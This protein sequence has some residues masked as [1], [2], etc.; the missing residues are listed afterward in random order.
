MNGLPS[1]AVMYKAL[2]NRDESFEGIFF[3]GVKSTGIFC[4]P[5]CSARKPKQINVEFYSSTGAA[6][7]AGYRPCKLCKPLGFKGEFPE[8]LK[9]LMEKVNNSPDLSFKD[10]DLRL[11]GT[12]PN[13]VRRWF[14]KNHGM[15]FQAYLRILRMGRAFGR[16]KF[17]E[18]VTSTAFSSGYGSLSG[19]TDSFKRIIGQS[20]IK[21]TGKELIHITRILTPLGP[22]LA[23]A[24]SAGVCLLEFIDRRMLET[25]IQ[26]LKNRLNGEFFPG[27]CIHFEKLDKEIGQYFAGKRKSFSVPLKLVG[28]QFQRKVWSELV[29]IPYGTTRAYNEIANLI[30]A[31][32]SVRAVANANGS[33]RIA[34]IIPCHRVIGSDGNL[35]GYGGGL[36]RKRYLLDMERVN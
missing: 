15:T 17:G 5:T 29:K 33:N 8:W 18:D 10:R 30:G 7:Q 16:I 3:V 12:D 34:I 6:L 11:F 19:F 32:R 13:R 14:K 22:M 4:R 27:K 31:E 23:G 21:S 1:N 36:W 26:I 25:Q 2:L 28:T 35:T 20:P 9:P 24:T